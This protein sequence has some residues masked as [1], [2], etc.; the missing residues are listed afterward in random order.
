MFTP[1][2]K[3]IL[4]FLLT[5]IAVFISLP[6]EISIK[7]RSFTRPDLNINIGSI[8]LQKSFDLILGLDLA[9]GA[10]LV[11]EAD[12]GN[13]DATERKTALESLRNVIERRVNLYGVSEPNVQSSSFEGKDRVIV[14]LPGVKDTRQ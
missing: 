12:T 3:V 4:I 5:L 10:H 9:G 7:D 6:R 11:F 2:K 8:S 1:L 14:E 13:L